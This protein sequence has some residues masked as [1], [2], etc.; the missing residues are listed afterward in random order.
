VALQR[1]E[2]SEHGENRS[3]RTW[4]NKNRIALDSVLRF[5]AVV[6]GARIFLLCWNSWASVTDPLVVWGADHEGRLSAGPVQRQ[7]GFARLGHLDRPPLRANSLILPKAGSLYDTQCSVWLASRTFNTYLLGSV[8]CQILRLLSRE[9]FYMHSITKAQNPHS[10]RENQHNCPSAD[11]VRESEDINSVCRET[12]PKV[13]LIALLHELC[14]RLA[15]L[16]QFESTLSKLST[17]SIRSSYETVRQHPSQ[18]D[19]SCLKADGGSW[20]DAMDRG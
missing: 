3:R 18:E 11:S 7:V 6:N 19:S 20:Q 2:K 5:D 13:V 17:I 8:G 4:Q 16:R 10:E 12:C 14:G 9:R 1:R 15:E